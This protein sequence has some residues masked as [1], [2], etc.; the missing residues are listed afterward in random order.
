MD[1]EAKFPK[2]ARAFRSLVSCIK[3]LSPHTNLYCSRPAFAPLEDTALSSPSSGNP[4]KG[5]IQVQFMETIS[6]KA[7]ISWNLYPEA[8]SALSLKRDSVTIGFR[9]R[10]LDRY[11]SYVG[12]DDTLILRADTNNDGVAELYELYIESEDLA[13]KCLYEIDCVQVKDTL[14]SLPNTVYHAAI[15]IPVGEFERIVNSMGDVNT[16]VTITANATTTTFLSTGQTSSVQV[17]LVQKPQ[18]PP[19]PKS[20][21]NSEKD[22][23][24]TFSQATSSDANTKSQFKVVAFNQKVSQTF[25]VKY[26]MT[27]SKAVKFSEVV[28]LHLC[29]GTPMK[30]AYDVLGKREQKTSVEIPSRLHRAESQPGSPGAIAPPAN[31]KSL[32]DNHKIGHVHYYL[33]GEEAP[34]FL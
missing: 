32:Q 1:F 14:T 23:A 20:S 18:G 10:E 15:Q 34:S 26:L 12:D 27:F 9:T 24:A 17:G 6:N 22:D 11:L 5:G 7:L 31:N 8:F 4:F 19:T 25:E 28:T 16:K 33:A 30:I 13:K 21:P 3:D 2:G 29:R